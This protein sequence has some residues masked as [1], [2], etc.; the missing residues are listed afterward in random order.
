MKL[1]GRA[2]PERVVAKPTIEVSPE[3]ERLQECSSSPINASDTRPHHCRTFWNHPAKHAGY[4]RP[5]HRWGILQAAPETSM[6]PT[7][8]W[9]SK[10]RPKSLASLGIGCVCFMRF[11]FGLQGSSLHS[12]G[13]KMLRPWVRS[14]LGPGARSSEKSGVHA[15]RLADGCSS[16]GSVETSSFLPFLA[17]I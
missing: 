10:V 4:I 6:K 3:D 5:S 12:C 13:F 7:R 11:G 1:L 17:V 16:Q 15:E 9:F 2:Q 8:G 14:M